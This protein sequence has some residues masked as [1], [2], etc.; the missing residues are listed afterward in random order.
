MDNVREML[1]DRNRDKGEKRVIAVDYMEQRGIKFK[2]KCKSYNIM[3][4]ETSMHVEKTM[5]KFYCTEIDAETIQKKMGLIPTDNSQ[6]EARPY[7]FRKVSLD[8]FFKIVD[9]L[10]ENPLNRN[11]LSEI[12]E[13][14]TEEDIK[15]C[16]DVKSINGEEREILTKARVNQGTIRENAMK[17][18]NGKCVLCGIGIDTA[19][20]ASHIKSWADSTSKEKGDHENVL[21]FCANHDALFDKHLIS[22]DDNGYLL[23]SAEINGEERKKLNI[24]NDM[25]IEMSA[26]MRGYM[27]YHRKKFEEK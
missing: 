20:R 8:D 13:K 22:F 6:D 14:V 12:Y 23:I 11:G 9:C 4:G 16:S 5:F 19:L 21:L 2:T 7:A 27:A 15:R 25:K 26:E 3:T 1:A 10:L 17:K 18:Y 24:S